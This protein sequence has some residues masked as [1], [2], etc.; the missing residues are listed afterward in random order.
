MATQVTQCPNCNTSFRVTEA[1]LNIAN[2]AVRCGSCLHIF[3]APDHW[4]DTTLHTAQPTTAQTRTTAE[5]QK[6]LFILEEETTAE[7]NT[8][9]RW[10]DDDNIFDDDIFAD[11]TDLDILAAEFLR[12]NDS[13]EDSKLATTD[14]EEE[15]DYLF[16]D[17][18]IEDNTNDNDTGSIINTDNDL[19]NL[20]DRNQI[21]FDSDDDDTLY[22]LAEDEDEEND[23]NNDDQDADNDGFSS[24]FLDLDR[25]EY[26]PP[27]I[28]KELDDIGNDSGPDEDDWAK[29]LLE[30]EDSEPNKNRTSEA[31]IRPKKQQPNAP[32]NDLAEIFDTHDLTPPEEEQ[33][34][35]PDA[36]PDIT[37]D[38][39]DI[40]DQTDTTADED[41]AEETFILG[42]ESLMSGERI[43]SHHSLLANIEP[44]PVQMPSY[45]QDSRWTKYGWTTAIVLALLLLVGQYLFFNFDRLARDNSLRPIF[46]AACPLLGCEVP[47]MDDIKLI[48][49]SN[50]MVRSHPSTQQAL[51]VDA[52]IINRAEFKQHFPSLELQ[53]TDLNGKLVADRRFTPDEYLAGELTG[54]QYM[55]IKQPIH[56]SLKIVDPGEQAVNYQLRFHPWR[57]NNA[58][59]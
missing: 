25:S 35:D 20:D 47:S 2:G 51:V 7:Q 29:K 8:I 27:S 23:S 54:S 37:T 45:R 38:L 49:S 58:A 1:Q 19:L 36:D 56:I 12:S 46:T 53:F 10:G 9:D 52:I 34:P 55:P 3:K 15:D 5:E 44:E 14:P 13:D 31:E 17:D 40:F 42:H 18:D 24:S 33:Y 22:G 57:D 59:K 6:P 48:R 11:E 16:A 41:D 21:I 26:A 28:F 30:D 4:L 32:L 50:L 43:G 39:P